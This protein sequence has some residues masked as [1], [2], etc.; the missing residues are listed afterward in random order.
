M[1]ISETNVTQIAEW[2]VFRK[3]TKSKDR[4]IVFF[5]GS[6]IGILFKNKNFYN[7]IQIRSTLPF[8]TLNEREK[9]YECYRVLSLQEPVDRHTILTSSLMERPKNAL[10][11]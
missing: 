1:S 4:L 2:L 5:L 8:D 9:F 11:Y 10:Q 3:S 6:R 7:Q